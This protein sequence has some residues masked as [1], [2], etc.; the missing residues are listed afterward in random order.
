MGT[1][2]K[3]SKT[4]IVIVEDSP[5]QA[6]KLRFFLEE[7]GFETAICL[8]GIHALQSVRERQPTLVIS[9]IIMPDMDGY[10]FC[11]AMKADES[12]KDIPVILLTSLRDPLDIIK[13]L[14]SMADNFITK[15]YDDQY[16]LNRIQ[17][18]LAN[19]QLR[20]Q[21]SGEMVMEVIFRGEKFQINSERKQIL[22]LLLSVYEAAIYQNEELIKTQDLLTSSNKELLQA[23]EELD[24]FNRTVTHDLRSPLASIKS[25]ISLIKDNEGKSLKDI[26]K[27]ISIIDEVTD[28]MFQLVDDL[29]RLS[30]VGAAQMACRTV[31]IGNLSRKIINTIQLASPTRNVEVIIESNLL[32]HADKGL[33]EVILQNL[34][35]NAWKYTGKNPNAR[36]HIGKEPNNESFEF[37]VS[38]NGA[39]FNME[40]AKNIFS[41]FERMHTS[42]EFPGVGIG[43]TTVKRIVERHGGT[44]RTEAEVDKGATFYFWLPTL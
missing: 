22:D 42:K 10:A 20:K 11:R 6:K 18:L 40:S 33:M 5:V 25:M 12:L 17:Y 19:R 16:L 9:D 44:I 39:G 35:G 37:F 8:N 4:Y 36:I 13:G 32:C 38:D 23:N 15:P 31:D 26:K 21:G 2:S 34:I 3:I 14:Q 1:T 24:A 28:K 30:Q 29:L 27:Y 7:S 43:L 41:P